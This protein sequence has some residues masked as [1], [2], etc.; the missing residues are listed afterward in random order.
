[1][2][3]AATKPSEAAEFVIDCARLGMSHLVAETP[4]RVAPDAG[5]VPDRLMAGRSIPA[6]R[7]PRLPTR[8]FPHCD[9]VPI[10]KP[11]SSFPSAPTLYRRY[12]PAVRAYLKD[13]PV[14]G[15]WGITAISW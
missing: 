9:H 15:A 13:A 8:R 7:S 10:G 14:K 3:V 2:N 11:R 1:M 5:T 12:P 6:T 4:D